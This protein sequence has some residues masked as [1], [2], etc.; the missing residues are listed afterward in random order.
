VQ[1][2]DFGVTCAGA[3]LAGCVA[4]RSRR[5]AVYVVMPSW[6]NLRHGRPMRGVVVGWTRP[7]NWFDINNA[8]RLPVTRNFRTLSSLSSPRST[9]VTIK[10]V[11]LKKSCTTIH[12]LKVPISTTNRFLH[13]LDSTSGYARCQWQA[14][15]YSPLLA[16]PW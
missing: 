3:I 4:L 11:R 7:D 12:T 5:V 6:C 2:A 14:F 15:G 9:I 13:G 8:P 1:G 16:F 10:L